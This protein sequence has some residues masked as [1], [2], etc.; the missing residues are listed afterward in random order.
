M[1][2]LFTLS[3]G[4]LVRGAVRLGNRPQET[5]SGLLIGHVLF[6]GSL[7]PLLQGCVLSV[8]IPIQVACRNNQVDHVCL[9]SKLWHQSVEGDA[10][11]PGYDVETII[12]TWRNEK[13]D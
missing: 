3:L 10:A 6:P 12:L 7:D 5:G 1:Y 9:P 8:D 2:R 13:D 11:M 4:K